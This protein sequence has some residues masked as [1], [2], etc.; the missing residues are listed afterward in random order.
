[1]KSLILV[2]AGMFFLFS[3]SSRAQVAPTSSINT[4]NDVDFTIEIP[5]TGEMVHF[6][7][8]E[9]LNTQIWFASGGPISK[10]R[11]FQNYQNVK[12]VGETTGN[13]YIYKVNR[14]I[15]IV[16]P[17]ASIV[18]EIGTAFVKCIET[19]DNWVGYIHDIVVI[20]ANGTVTLENEERYVLC[21]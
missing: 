14:L 7:G 21:E 17:N 10:V 3:Q 8:T 15:K 5:C 2:L 11:I 19:K 4:I 16:Q 20:N 13:T 18:S 9:H 1:M 12:G 6:T